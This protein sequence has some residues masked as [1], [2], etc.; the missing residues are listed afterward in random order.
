MRNHEKP[1][2]FW[3]PIDV[4]S[5][6]GIQR[7]VSEETGVARPTVNAVFRGT[8]RASQAVAIA[9]EKFFIGAGIPLNRWDLLL[10]IPDGQSLVDYLARVKLQGTKWARE[11]SIEKEE[12][13]E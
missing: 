10:Y 5:E 8:R 12:N 9:L 7:R 6:H 3:G 13:H 2:P 1:V 11:L 4:L